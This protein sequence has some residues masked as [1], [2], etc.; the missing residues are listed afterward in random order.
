MR[1]IASFLIGLLLTGTVSAQW[2]A[3]TSSRDVLALS[4]APGAIWAASSGG[5][6]R[7]DKASGEING[8]TVV[9]GLY[10]IQ[11]KSLAY[12]PQRDMVWIGYG[13]GTLDRLEVSSGVV[14]TFFDIQRSERFPSKDINR[15]YIQGDSLL[16]ATDFGLVVFDPERAEVRDTYTKLGSFSSPVVVRDLIFSEIPQ[17]GPGMWL[18]TDQGVAFASLDSPNLQDP[19]AWTTE[20]AIFPSEN[21]NAIAEFGGSIY[22]GSAHGLNQRTAT[23][24]YPN[25]GRTTR[26]VLDMGVLSD[27]LLV[28]TA[29]A[30]NGLTDAGGYHSHAP[31]FLSLRALIVDDTQNFWVGDRDSG[32]NHYDQPTGTTQATLLTAEIYPEGPYDSPFGD[33]VVDAQGSLWAAQ[34]EGL[35]RAGFYR[36]DRDGS[37]T[38]YTQRFYTELVG[39]SNYWR[40]YSDDQGNTWAGSRGGGLAQVTSD[41]TISVFDHT[42]SS[43]LPASATESYVIVAGMTG[44]DDGGVWFTNMAAPIPLHVRSADGQWASLQPISCSG[45]LGSTTTL[46]LIYHDSGGIKWIIVND[47]NDLRLTIGI[48]ALDTQGTPA[49]ALDDQCQFFGGRGSGGRGL[50]S[51]QINA[52][53]EDGSG[54]VWIGTDEGPAYFFTSTLAASDPSVDASWPVID[55]GTDDAAYLFRGLKINDIVVDP[56]GQIWFATDNGAYLVSDNNGFEIEDRFTADNSPLLSDN[57]IAISVDGTTGLVYMSTDKGLVSYQGRSVEPATEVQDLFV[58]PNPVRIEGNND[59]EIAIEGLV[60]ETTVKIITVHGELVQELSVRGGR[61]TWN[62][63][64]RNGRLVPSGIFLVAAIGNNGEGTAFGKI[65][66]IR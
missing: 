17:G 28:L 10:D 13:D 8:Y 35:V 66:V 45:G 1:R 55:Q 46:G 39:K 50:P 29:F 56:S 65:A 47:R 60:A 64:D 21:L 57:V 6:F 51:P 62:G 19:T 49:D 14:R 44:D 34:V 63:R 42:N 27:R 40:I 16:I 3:Y 32:L 5:I 58:Y 15:L 23:G 48:L 53:T 24:S 54:R 20:N 22:V 7:Y 37:W 38:N 41:G 52:L 36:L 18:A 31:G 26:E 12:D 30:V 61:V 11:A 4:D 25:T 59:P 2:Q 33:M 9:D 43:L